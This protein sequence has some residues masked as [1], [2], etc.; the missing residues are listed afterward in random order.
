MPQ[1]HGR[2]RKT[3]THVRN[4]VSE[5]N[6]GVPRSF[7]IRRGRLPA[8]ARQLALELR[9]ALMPHTASRLQE[10]PSNSLKDYVAIAGRLG[11][12]HLWLL[13]AT[14]LGVY[15]RV[16]R[17]PRGPTL[18]FKVLE[19]S[20]Q[21]EVKALQRRPLILSNEDFRDPPLLVMHRFGGA[22][23]EMRVM[24]ATFENMFPALDVRTIHLSRVR[25]VLLIEYDPDEDAVHI[26]HYKLLVNPVGLSRPLRKLV[27]RNKVPKLS[28]MKDI[29]E[30]M[31]PDTAAY[32]S[33][34]EPE[35][36]EASQ[37][38]LPQDLGT[39]RKK[40]AKNSIKLV[41][42]GPRL[43]LKLMK[44]EDGLCGGMVLYNSLRENASEEV[45]D[46]AQQL[47]QNDIGKVQENG[48]QAD[49][50]WKKKQKQIKRKSIKSTKLKP[51]ETA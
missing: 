17:M 22:S 8:G 45:E 16:A 9:T 6:D 42:Q 24:K 30:F 10:R 35:P 48:N 50:V 11:I 36:D 34:S 41:E 51:I 23:D 13:S 5:G 27:V 12:T 3:R 47:E 39:K 26:R 31:K 21:N 49:P 7:V 19:Y 32:S 38:V 44:V 2:R 20:L 18:S 29:S 40:G 14:D 1:K 37:I 28:S 4:E 43:T 25:R 15:L 33:D 46:S